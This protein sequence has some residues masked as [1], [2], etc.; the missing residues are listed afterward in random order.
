MQ[1]R[2]KKQHSIIT[3]SRIPEWRMLQKRFIHYTSH[4]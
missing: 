1:H 2:Q 3:I 4:R